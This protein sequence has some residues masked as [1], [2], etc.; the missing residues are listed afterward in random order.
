MFPAVFYYFF[1]LFWVKNTIFN[2]KTRKLYHFNEPKD[3]SPIKYDD[4]NLGYDFRDELNKFENNSVELNNIYENLYKKK[5]LDTLENNHTS[6][7]YKIQLLNN[8]YYVG[9]FNLRNGGL[10]HN[11]DFDF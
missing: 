11:Q 10:F 4:Y 5:I 9:G 6:I 7:M 8:L 2:L 3:L 1:L